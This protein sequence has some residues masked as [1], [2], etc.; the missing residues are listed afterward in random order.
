MEPI[1]FP[2]LILHPKPPRPPASSLWGAQQKS[3]SVHDPAS[4][5]SRTAK[6]RALKPA[7]PKL[8]DWFCHLPTMTSGKL[9]ITEMPYPLQNRN[10]RY[11]PCWG[12]TRFKHG[13]MC[14]RLSTALDTEETLNRWD[15]LLLPMRWTLGMS[16]LSGLLKH[17]IMSL[18]SISWQKTDKVSSQL[19][20]SLK[21]TLRRIHFLICKMWV[22]S[23][24]LPCKA[25]VSIKQIMRII[26]TADAQWSVV[27]A[28]LLMTSYFK[29][30]S[31]HFSHRILCSSTWPFR[32]AKY[33]RG[34]WYFGFQ[35]PRTTHKIRH[36][37]RNLA[38]IQPAE[39]WEHGQM[40]EEGRVW[41][42]PGVRGLQSGA[43]SRSTFRN[44]NS[45]PSEPTESGALAGA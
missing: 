3:W 18:E 38:L 14:E 37:K 32:R 19:H 33:Q 4:E 30:S 21:K 39:V 28:T 36:C 13:E 29:A 41:F 34:F 24:L 20:G 6:S 5:P 25:I 8:E 15:S 26:H 43:F 40:T 45:Q 27:A 10:S 17:C 22:T 44:A 1:S 23:Q 42:R 12:A 7:A 2:R 35:S 31:N 11:L 16:F 9:R